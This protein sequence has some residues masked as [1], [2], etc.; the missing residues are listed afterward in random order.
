M[1]YTLFCAAWI[2]ICFARWANFNV[3]C[4]SS[5]LLEEGV[6]VHMSW[7]LKN[8]R[9]TYIIPAFSTV[10]WREGKS[11]V[12][13]HVLITLHSTSQIIHWEI[14]SVS[15]ILK[16]TETLPWPLN[17]DWRS[18]VNF[19]SLYGTCEAFPSPNFEI[20]CIQHSI[21]IL[22]S[23]TQILISSFLRK[24]IQ[25]VKCKHTSC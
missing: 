25:Y 9:R 21:N 24:G 22:V 4:V 7:K 12:H 6:T 23:N 1:Q 10:T 18:L 5:E 8:I 11:S 19:E 15:D 13:M 16:R 20:T 2:S 3:L 14:L 17:E